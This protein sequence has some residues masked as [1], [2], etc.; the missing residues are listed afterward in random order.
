M[1][2]EYITIGIIVGL[3]IGFIIAYFILSK[4]KWGDKA[5]ILDAKYGKKI[6]ELEGSYNVKLE[7]INTTLQ[8]TKEENKT[9]LE[10]LEK[11]WKIKYIKDIEELKRLF[12]ESEKVIKE[13]SVSS[14]RRSL[15]GKFIE[16]FVPFLSK[17]KYSPADMHFLGQPVDYI[18]FEGSKDDNIKRVI[19]LEVKTGQ[20][21][22]TKREKTLKETIE[23]KR[24]A[25]KEIRVDTNEDNTPDKD[26]EEKE[27]A[28]DNLYDHIESNV[29]KVKS[30]IKAGKYSEI[31][32]NYKE[33]ESNIYEVECP[34]C[35]E[36]FEI[37]EDENI[38]EGK[39]TSKRCPYCKKKIEIQF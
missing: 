27:T 8:K 26:I 36:I 19:F 15:V 17:H 24:V 16:K 32:E 30:S 9:N 38:E 7:K 14:S 1:N 23:K 12:K 25:W 20:G 10:K 35:G 34:E 11:D 33:E 39:I 22:L 28:I 13:K 18:V 21:K 2:F 3:F 31:E 29:N 37:E 4:Q 5:K 6:A